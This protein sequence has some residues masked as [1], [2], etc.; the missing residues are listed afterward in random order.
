M[1]FPEDMPLN[2]ENGKRVG[3]I[4]AIDH[5][6]GIVEGRIEDPEYLKTIQ[7]KTFSGYSFTQ[8]PRK[9][10]VAGRLGPISGYIRFDREKATNE[11]WKIRWE[12]LVRRDPGVLF[13]DNGIKYPGVINANTW[14]DQDTE[15][16]ES[17][18]W[19]FGDRAV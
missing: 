7:G 15:G 13:M 14:R 17:I 8:D 5:K 10:V 9:V 19:E 12:Q 11:S 6:R 4:S 1:K 2:D 18:D 16:V 3:T